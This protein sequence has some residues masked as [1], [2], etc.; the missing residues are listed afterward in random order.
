MATNTASTGNLSDTTK[1]SLSHVP[2][3]GED[4]VIPNGVLVTWDAGASSTI[5]DSGD[6][7]SLTCSGTGQLTIPLDVVGSVRINVT[8]KTAGTSTTGAINVTG[9][10]PAAVLTISTA[11]DGY[12]ALNV[13]ST[14]T[15]IYT[16]TSGGLLHRGHVTC[17]SSGEGITIYSGGAA[18]VKQYGDL[19][20]SGQ[21]GI[22]G[23]L[24]YRISGALL[25]VHDSNITGSATAARSA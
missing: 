24:F 7:A 14:G 3:A 25:E 9:V 12:S 22:F 23:A 17:T 5:P 20:A 13:A 11:A 15:G 16:T 18:S 21:T 19:N 1:W 10:A 8:T 4:V 6:L 2:I